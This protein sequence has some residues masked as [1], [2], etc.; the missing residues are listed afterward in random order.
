MFSSP[1]FSVYMLRDLKFNYVTYVIINA[2][3]TLATMLFMPLWGKRVDKFGTIQ[4]LKVS[5]LFVPLVPVMWLFSTNAYYLCF[6]QVLGGFC[7][8]RFFARFRHLSI[9]AAPAQNRIRY[10]ALSNTLMFGGSAL[11]ALFGGIIA[12]H[13]PV[14]MGDKLLTVFLISEWREL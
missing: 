9:Y 12:P 11:G 14:V 10:I 1:F 6:A 13:L 2:A 8:G 7:L 4:V 5:S 3:S